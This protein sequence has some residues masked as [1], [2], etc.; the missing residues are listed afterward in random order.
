MRVIRTAHQAITWIVR[1]IG[2][3]FVL[4]IVVGIVSFFVSANL[5]TIPSIKA[6]PW[7][8]QTYSNDQWHIPSRI[9]LAER[10]TTD[11]N[12]I[13]TITTYW[14]YDGKKWYRHGGSMS[15]PIAEYG[16]IDIR[17]RVAE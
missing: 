15:F 14:T 7:A 8:I 16:K 2:C 9:Y 17:R 5:H 13:P 4:L 3:L 1:G 6:A 11:K 12:A 10:V